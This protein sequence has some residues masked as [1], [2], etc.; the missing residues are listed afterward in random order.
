VLE[1]LDE[2]EIVALV[3]LGIFFFFVGVG[4]WEWWGLLGFFCWN[5][6]FGLLGMFLE[7]I[8]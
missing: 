2:V 5:E 1:L 8:G 3:D 4:W 6:F 7:G